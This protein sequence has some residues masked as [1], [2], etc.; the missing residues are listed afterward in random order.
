MNRDLFHIIQYQAL[1]T[2][3]GTTAIDALRCLA[4]A[5]ALDGDNDD[6]CEVYCTITEQHLQL[7]QNSNK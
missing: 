6:L 7:L 5:C 3:H 1:L 2:E 4:A